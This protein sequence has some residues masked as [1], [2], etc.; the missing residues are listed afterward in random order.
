VR[1][2]MSTRSEPVKLV[3]CTRHSA[4]PVRNWRYGLFTSEGP[5]GRME[6]QV[7]RKGGVGRLFSESLSKMWDV[8]RG[9]LAFLLSGQNQ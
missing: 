4:R 1:K 7:A 2:S 5:F 8:R 6:W 9:E 3:S